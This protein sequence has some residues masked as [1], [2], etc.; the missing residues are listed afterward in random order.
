VGRNPS[1]RSPATIVDIARVAG[2]SKSTVSL[3]LNGDKRV[4]PKTRASVE[5]AISR[6]GYIYNRNAA[7]LRGATS[8]LIGLVINDLTNPFFAELAAGIEDAL[9]KLGLVPILA[10]TNESP[11]RQAQVLQSLR[12]HGVAGIIMCPAR[13]TDT[14]TLVNQLPPS[15]PVVITTRRISGTPLPYV[16]ADNRL[17]AHQAIAHLVRLG[18]RRIGF[19]GGDPKMTTHK[20]REAG[21]RDALTEAGLSIDGS[22]VFP[23]APT[24]RGGF[25]AMEVALAMQPL[26]S[27]VL[28]YNDI[29][30]IGATR[31]LI[32]RDMVPGKD[33][34]IIGFD[35]IAEAQD[36]A[37][38]LTTVSGDTKHLGVR[39]AESLLGLIRGQDP[40]ALSYDGKT[41]LIIRES[42]GAARLERKAS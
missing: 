37:P 40:A 8:S 3:V 14:W 29:V 17:G 25:E 36:N 13:G 19:L 22:L 10:N 28:C 35:D 9:F 31:A 34:A 32:N 38:P 24:R 11:D 39:C 2:V 33:M 20:E 7:N 27:A 23:G 16:G 21:W 30:A 4:R 41:R 12:E 6:L 5:A 15:I 26:P 42:C 18:H 1:A